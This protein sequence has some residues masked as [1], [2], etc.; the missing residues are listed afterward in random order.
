MPPLRGWGGRKPGWGVAAEMPARRGLGPRDNRC[1]PRV[2]LLADLHRRALV[3]P[4]PVVYSGG[5][6]W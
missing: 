5:L 3:M 1:A 4:R 6:G 2:R